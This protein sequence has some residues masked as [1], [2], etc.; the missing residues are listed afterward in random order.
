[1]NASIELATRFDIIEAGS[2]FEE[3]TVAVRSGFHLRF[4]PSI[5]LS[6]SRLESV[7]LPTLGPKSARPRFPISEFFR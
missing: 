6:D 2:S 3:S 4:N 5:E 7:A 1:M